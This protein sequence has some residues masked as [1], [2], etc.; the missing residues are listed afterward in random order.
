M[1][2]SFSEKNLY[3]FSQLSLVSFIEI[4]PSWWWNFY[5]PFGRVLH[6]VNR[7]VLSVGAAE[8]AR[9]LEQH[10]LC[11]SALFECFCTFPFGGNFKIQLRWIPGGSRWLLWCERVLALSA[12]D[13]T[14][15][16]GKHNFFL[17]LCSLLASISRLELS[18]KRLKGPPG[19]WQR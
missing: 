9:K 12:W 4:G 7:V 17:S 11:D 3:T 10:R 2:K 18:V 5:F 14:K 15:T 19:K 8:T 6:H 16:N 13:E 1:E